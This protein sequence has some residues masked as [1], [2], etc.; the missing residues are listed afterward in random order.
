MEKEDSQ[1]NFGEVDDTCLTLACRI[2][3]R[4]LEALYCTITVP[5]E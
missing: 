3:Y 4:L 5:L 1:R 2:F